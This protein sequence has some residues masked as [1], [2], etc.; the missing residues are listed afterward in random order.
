MLSANSLI[1]MLEHNIITVL[2]REVNS[3]NPQ[4]SPSFPWFPPTISAVSKVLSTS[5][6]VTHRRRTHPNAL[7]TQGTVSFAS[8]CWTYATSWMSAA[9][10]TLRRNSRSTFA[11]QTYCGLA[12]TPWRQQNLLLVLYLSLP[13][14]TKNALSHRFYTWYFCSHKIERCHPMTPRYNRIARQWCYPEW[15]MPE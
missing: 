10:V 3:T 11:T 12:L 6:T 2:T 5:L 1:I 7:S 4:Y 9:P 15:T 13:N 8:L 14:S